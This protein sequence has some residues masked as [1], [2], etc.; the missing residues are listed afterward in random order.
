MATYTTNARILKAYK[1]SRGRYMG[2]GPA[3]KKVTRI[4]MVSFWLKR[5]TPWYMNMMLHSV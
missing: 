2:L 5:T 3:N 4:R 1:V